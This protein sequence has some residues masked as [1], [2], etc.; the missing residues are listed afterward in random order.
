M[1]EALAYVDPGSGYVFLQGSSF[2][3][4]WLFTILMF[5]I[6]PFRFLFR[7]I[8]KNAWKVICL[9]IIAIIIIIVGVMMNSPTNGVNVIIL[10]IDAMDPDI[11]L[12]LINEGKL[13]HFARLLKDGSF[14][15]LS[16]S[17][18]AESAVAWSS[19][20]T[21]LNPGEHGIF[22][23][24]MRDPKNYAPYLSLS[25]ENFK[26]GKLEIKSRIRAE[27]FWDILSKNKIP[28][29]IYFCPNTFPAHKIYG[30]LISGMGVPDMLGMVGK[31]SFYTNTP[32]K[33]TDK[34]SRGKIIHVAPNQGIVL[35]SLYGP[36]VGRNN[37]VRD[38]VVPLKI[39]LKPKEDKINIEFLGKKISLKKGEWCDWQEVSFKLG[40]FKKV[41]GIVR[42]YLKNVTPDFE[43][44]ASPIN[45]DPKRP[46]FPISWPPNFSAKLAED[47]GLFYT[48]GMPHDTWAL[49]EDRIDE[50]AFL[51]HAD[52]ILAEREKILQEELKGFKKGVF[53]FYFDTLDALQHMFWRYIDEESLLYEK[54]S[55]Y[56][57]TIY[58]YYEKMDAI[59]GRVLQKINEDTVLIV[60]SD[61]GFGPFRKSVH[62]NRWL[63]ENGFFSLKSGKT[64]GREFF[65]DI[66]WRNTR[67]YALGFGGIYLNRLGREKLGI[68]DERETEEL[69]Q[70]IINRL[71]ELEDPDTK[72][73]VISDVYSANSIFAGTNLRDAPDLF[74]G[75]NRGYRASWQTALG[76]VPRALMEDNKK[77]WSGDHLVDPKLVQGILFT[78]WK[79]ASLNPR[80]TDIAGTV[81]KA[82]NIPAPEKLKGREIF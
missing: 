48:Q 53:F 65:E 27:S 64:E 21:G 80:I 29:F 74:V 44:Y 63:L 2:L 82:F 70:Q 61:H 6:F 46:L 25:E 26:N 17:N 3:W 12:K 8:K 23:F 58:T 54:D 77:K 10:G 33:D 76:G 42:F 75:F 38:S 30:K 22:D 14:A 39:T 5:F 20:A 72:E 15:R 37:F 32:Q 4:G 36:K 49:S 50:K 16:T 40:L 60:L 69:K 47:V 68:V 18:P 7:R 41:H 31:F 43:L 66:D 73:K 45:F 19:F 78:N 28:S 9:V 81:L 35:T 59:L 11:T 71:K 1:Q 56:K 34:D 51:G 79:I 55:I 52:I 24:V 67:A 13:P 57:D 62:L